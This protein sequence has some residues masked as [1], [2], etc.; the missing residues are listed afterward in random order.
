MPSMKTHK[1]DQRVQ[2]RRARDIT[3]LAA[4]FEDCVQSLVQLSDVLRANR[5]HSIQL[6]DLARQCS[7]RLEAWAADSGASSRALDYTLKCSPVLMRQTLRLLTDL[8]VLL[9]QVIQG[10]GE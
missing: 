2:G 5:R 7:V 4:Q 8:H 3:P 6:H 10:Q 1:R 9:G